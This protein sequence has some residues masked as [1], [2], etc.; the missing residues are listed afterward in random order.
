VLFSFGKEDGIMKP[1][2]LLPGDTI[3]IVS[4][5]WGGAGAF[6]QRVE[7]AIQHIHTLGFQTRLAPHALNQH[8]HVSDS[9]ENRAQDINQMFADP[10]VK[11]ILAAIGGDHSCQLLPYLDYNLIQNNPK[12][13]MG[14]SD[15]TVLNIAL[16]S[17]TGLGTFNGPALLTDFAEYPRMLAYSEQYFLKVVTDPAPAGII[18]P[19]PGWTEEYSHWAASKELERQR[20][21]LP[22]P[23]WTWLRAASATGRLAGGC[24]ESL[25]HLRGT[26]FWPNWHDVII[27]FETSEDKPSPEIV[28]GILADYENMGVLEQIKG[29]LVGRPMRYS[30]QEKRQLHEVILERTRTYHF[31]IIAE[32][33]FGHTSPQFTLPIGCLAAIDAE[34]RYFEILE[35]AVT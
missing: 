23:G 30:E 8:G 1:G 15:I 16:W 27:F 12:I 4:P 25:Q 10:Q 13:F 35:G 26:G 6:P 19:S 5:S 22:S 21:L 14:F 32:M 3:G 11:M 31:P 7:Q 17:R 34:R 20:S 29:M 33:D 24:I 18:S 2:R 28:D 9:P